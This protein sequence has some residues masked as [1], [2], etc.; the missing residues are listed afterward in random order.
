MT[1]S[2]TTPIATDDWPYIYLDRPRIPMLY[3]LLTGLLTVLM[4]RGIAQTGAREVTAVWGR[5]HWHFFFL[6]AA[7]ML[8]EVQNI[9]KAAVVLGNTWLVNAVII[10]GILAMVLLANLVFA[11]WSSIPSWP[12]YLGLCG[13]CG[14]IFVLDLSQFAFLPYVTKA[15]IVGGL[16]SLPMLFSGIIF[17]QSFSR[18]AHKNQ[19]LGA[20]LIGALVGA[21]MQSVTFVTGIRALLLIVIALYLAALATRPMW[22]AVANPSPPPKAG[23]LFSR[24]RR[25]RESRVA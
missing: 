6:G 24:R 5:T 4:I 17:I 20:N 10:S 23:S 14:L 7:F 11:R 12:I 13:A 18:V 1:L 19:A 16:T 9:S 8:L 21:L 15:L 22:S 25:D 3:F 2:G